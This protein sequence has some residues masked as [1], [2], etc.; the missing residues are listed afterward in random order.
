MRHACWE[1]RRCSLTAER[2][3]WI[4]PAPWRKRT[5]AAMVTV[6]AAAM[7]KVAAAMLSNERA[8]GHSA[9][10]PVSQKMGTPPRR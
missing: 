4:G 6:V 8:F 10:A 2:F 7:V 9:V 1:R 5:E 3:E